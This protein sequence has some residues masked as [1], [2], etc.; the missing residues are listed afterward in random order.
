[1]ARLI[2]LFLT[3]LIL[4]P[5][6]SYPQENLF[7]KALDEVGFT[8]EDL[9]Y[10]PKGYWNRYPN[11]ELIPYKMPHFDD[12]F[13]EPMMGYQYAVSMGNVVEDYLEPSFMAE[14]RFSLHRVVYM[15]GVDRRV[16]G[17]RNYSVN[18]HAQV[19]STRPVIDALEKIFAYKGEEMRRYAFGDMAESPDYVNMAEEQ[20]VYMHKNIQIE[21]AEA[22][23][24]IL[25]AVK[26]RDMALRNV[27]PGLIHEVFKINNLGETQG[28]GTIYYPQFDDISAVI[29]EQSL[30]YACMKAVQAAEN[31][32][33]G[34]ED[35]YKD[36]Y[37]DFSKVQFEI[38]TP[39]GRVAVN[40]DEKNE[41]NRNDYCLVIDFEGNDK[42]HGSVGAASNADI[43]VSICLDF[44]GNDKYINENDALAS[45]GAGLFGCGVLI[46]VKGRDSYKSKTLSQG[47][48]MFGMG[49][50]F[51]AEGDDEY[52]METSGQGCGYFG[53][54]F[55][56]DVEGKDE[57]YLYGDGQGFGGVGGGVGILGNYS[58][59]DKYVA[60][61]SAEIVNR[62]DYHSE[63]KINVS[64]AQGAAAGRRGDGSD[65]HSWAGGLGA[66]IDIHGKDRYESGNWSLGT[67]YW[68][69]TGIAYDKTGDDYYKSVYFTQ[70][71]GAHY[72][73]GI[74]IDESGNDHHELW[75][76]SGAALSFGWDYTTSLLVDKGGDD[77]YEGKIISIACAEIRSNSFF[78]DIGGN[79]T[80]RLGEG[81]CGMGGV[82]W[83]DSYRYPNRYSP[84]NALAKSLAVFIDIGGNDSY[85]DWDTKAEEIRP[86]DKYSN[87]ASWLN[88]PKDDPKHGWNNYGVGIDAEEGTIP[89]VYF[90]KAKPEPEE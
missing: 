4:I 75:E 53:C 9:G 3:I 21:I 52:A 58:G 47:F 50:L 1:M 37:L 18:L 7:Q 89:E 14:K 28:D 73:I 34:I 65:G 74:M 90:F 29:D 42:Y 70:A 57:Y 79:D 13:A 49:V 25:D 71:S 26:W 63:M 33:W 64:M 23:L 69:G 48:G 86:S 54:G 83:R 66:I 32:R 59:D 38:Y 2:S 76:T 31:A 51:D 55:N 77:Y 44:D 15:L 84:Y 8:Y 40:G 87:N 45:Q 19:D 27:P 62:G 88:P 20:L 10:K 67:G 60:E 6:L 22:L 68:Y 85:Q 82:D 61:P 35:L 81:Q 39:I 46:D 43:P 36:E 17:F 5:S 56:L 80:Y 72:C 12:L 16:G 30:Y 11:P 24:N 41:Y 78:F